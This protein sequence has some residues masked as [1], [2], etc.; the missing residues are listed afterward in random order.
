MEI[1]GVLS[2]IG[3]AEELSESQ[4]ALLRARVMPLIATTEQKAKQAERFD[5]ALFLGGFCGSLVVT[6]ATAINLAGYVTPS[7]SSAVST[8]ILVLSSLATATLALRERLRLR[9]MAVLSRRCSCLLQ[10]ALV[11][12]LAHAAPYTAGPRRAFRQF[13]WDVEIIKGLADEAQMRQREEDGGGAG[14]AGS[15]PGSVRG[16]VPGSVPPG[17]VPGSVPGGIPGGIAGSV[18]AGSV[19]PG[20][21]LANRV[22]DVLPLQG[23]EF[24]QGVGVSVAAGDDDGTMLPESGNP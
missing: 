6:I 21:M 13:V 9:E 24:D 18:L 10:R 8:G 20:G 2:L 5:S 19:P 4:R 22:R 3:A 15:I 1:Q 11:L 14:V 23:G 17:S 12:F 7:A 16:T